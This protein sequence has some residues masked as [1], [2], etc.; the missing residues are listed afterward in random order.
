[1]NLATLEDLKAAEER[2]LKAFDSL[3]NH[4]MDVKPAK[5]WLKTNEFMTQYSIKHRDTLVKMRQTGEV[6]GEKKLGEWYYDTQSF[7]PT[8]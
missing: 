8:K 4:V 7:L 3:K 6:K 5:R 2:I 1:M